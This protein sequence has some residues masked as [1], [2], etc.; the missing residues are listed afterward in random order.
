MYTLSDKSKII[1][2]MKIKN[3]GLFTFEELYQ[4]MIKWFRHYGYDWKELE[5]KRVDNPDGSQMIDVRWECP[6]K[7]DNYV[8]VVTNIFIKTTFSKVEVS[9]GNEKKMMDKGDCEV[10]LDVAMLKNVAV[11]EGR[12]LGQVAGLVYDKILIKERLRYYE[13]EIRNES[14]KLINEVKEYLAIYAI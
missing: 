2:G 14:I 13:D 5:Y 7:I 1:D 11:W 3:K 8:S 4:E 9:I 10:K 6:K 12:P